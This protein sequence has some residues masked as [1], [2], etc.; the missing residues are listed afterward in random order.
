M[1]LGGLISTNTT[2]DTTGIPL[3]MDIPWLGRLFRVDSDSERRT[4]LMMLI[5]P[6]IIDNHQDAKAVTEAKAGRIEYR[7]EKSGIIHAP[8]GKR[9]FGP[10]KLEENLRALFKELIRVRPSAVKGTYVK[11]V[12][13]SGTMTPSLRIDAGDMS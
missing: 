2:T 5:V 9:S 13:I 7:V 10:E 4:E 1:L 3:L 12:F 8:V 11:S 6:Y